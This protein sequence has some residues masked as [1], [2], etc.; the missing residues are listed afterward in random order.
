MSLKAWLL[1][2][3][4][5]GSR[6]TTLH[7]HDDE[8]FEFKKLPIKD[9][10]FI[11]KEGEKVIKAWCHF[12]KTQFQFNGYR[13]I[14][15]DQVT[16]TY[17]RDIFYDPYDIL[18]PAE[19]PLKQSAFAGAKGEKPYNVFNQPYIARIATSKIYEA[20]KQKKGSTI[21][22]KVAWGLLAVLGF[23]GAILLLRFAGCGR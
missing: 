4:M 18:S 14:S 1:G 16:I 21:M 6:R 2:T 8:S 3:N 15:G 22:D 5:G 20:Q 12:F 10:F 13:G 11:L 7:F 23:E 19:K 9:T 17:D